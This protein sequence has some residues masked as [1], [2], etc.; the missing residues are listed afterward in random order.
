MKKILNI[1]LSITLAASTAMTFQ[2][3][4]KDPV[5]VDYSHTEKVLLLY[6]AGFNSL[7][8]YLLDDINDLMK[9]GWVPEGPAS[10]SILL[11]YTHTPKSGGAY[12]TQTSP[13]LIRLYRD[14]KDIVV[15]D[16]L[17]TYPAETISSSGAQ[18]NKV[19]TK[20]KNTFPSKSYGMIF[21]SHATGYLPAG[22]YQNPSSYTFTKS[23]LMS[24]GGRNPGIPTPVPYIEPEYDPSLPMVK[25]IGQDQVG[26]RGN[27]LSYEMEIMDFAE[28]IPMKLDYI[29]FDACLMGGVEVAYELRE[30]V[31][32]IGFSQAE[33]LAEG[34]DYKSLTTHLLKNGEPDPKTVCEDYFNQYDI[35]S[36]VHR[37]ATIS[38]V[39]TEGMDRLASLCLP[40]FEKYRGQIIGLDK[41][42]I[43]DFGGS[44]RYFFDLFDIIR[45]SG[46]TDDELAAI[47]NA[48]D[49]IMLYKNTTGQYYSA[50][51]SSVHQIPAANFSGL[52]M[53]LPHCGSTELEKF[54]KTLSWNEATELVQ[55]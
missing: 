21:S 41:N 27:Y 14:Q 42:R 20:V 2:S 49:D 16:T 32:K 25:S 17:V 53:Y 45:S 9:K 13:Y 51:D 30:K 44:K 6:S 3:C 52:T 37:S 1:L 22:Y 35:Q 43:Q 18:L 11:V 36:G 4:E 47:Q 12:S 26:T 23:R 54:Y 10:K 39:N 55:Y 29:L 31:G 24:T 28:A 38:L 46:A 33:V 34:L 50:T 8:S 15:C 40:L 5:P 48:L 19:L 7:R